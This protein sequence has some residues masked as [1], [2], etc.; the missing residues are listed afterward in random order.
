MKDIVLQTDP[1]IFDTIIRQLTM[2]GNNKSGFLSKMRFMNKNPSFAFFNKDEH[3]Y[4]KIE[5]IMAASKVVEQVEE[6][7]SKNIQEEEYRSR[8]TLRAVSQRELNP[9]PSIVDI[10]ASRTDQN[11][12]KKRNPRASKKVLES[13][14]TANQDITPS[15]NK[16]TNDL[17]SVGQLSILPEQPQRINRNI[18]TFLIPSKSTYPKIHASTS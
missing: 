15:L 6:S 9:R 3:N 12:M 13:L 7:Y 17:T 11:F 8:P 2:Q 10:T 4:P 1:V 16:L 5:E 14:E 18:N